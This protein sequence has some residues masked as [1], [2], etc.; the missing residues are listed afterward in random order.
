MPKI[1]IKLAYLNK[2]DG[3]IVQLNTN[4]SSLEI[5]IIIS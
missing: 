3:L 1:K 2:E 5:E 4:K